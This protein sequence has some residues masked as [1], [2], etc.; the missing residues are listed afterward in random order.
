MRTLLFNIA[1]KTYKPFDYLKNPT[2]TDDA[3]V[4]SISASA[5]GILRTLT[6]GGALI[7]LSIYI[8]ISL[9]SGV[10]PK[11]YAELKEVVGFKILVVFL[12]CSFTSICTLVIE[13][14]KKFI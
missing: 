9:L 6:L 2:I 10:N 5:W 13:I 1:L 14:A 7:S 11:K 8:I 12:F 4:R 3:R